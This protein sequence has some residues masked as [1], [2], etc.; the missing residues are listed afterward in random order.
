MSQLEFDCRRR[1]L[2]IHFFARLESP[3]DFRNVRGAGRRRFQV[4]CQ[5]WGKDTAFEGSCFSGTA[6]A[7]RGDVMGR[8]VRSTARCTGHDC[9]RLGWGELG[10]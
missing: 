10:I 2:E 6:N 7:V 8:F 3:L 4:P 5:I 9:I 1:A